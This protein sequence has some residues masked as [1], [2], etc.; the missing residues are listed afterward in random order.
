MYIYLRVDIPLHRG[1][2]RLVS[3][4]VL[5]TWQGS[6]FA[7]SALNSDDEADLWNTPLSSPYHDAPPSSTSRDSFSSSSSKIQRA[8]T[9]HVLSTEISRV[10]PHHV[11]SHDSV[12]PVEYAQCDVARPHNVCVTLLCRR[13][14]SSQV[15]SQRSR[16][17]RSEIA[18]GGPWTT[19]AC[20]C[21]WYVCLSI[22]VS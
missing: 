5:V 21:V 14:T 7:S 19:T 18:C 12:S 2:D 17:S 20:S 8:L 9:A 22:A 15:R 3:K 1:T 6:E 11:R 13:S 10:F 16:K 4:Y